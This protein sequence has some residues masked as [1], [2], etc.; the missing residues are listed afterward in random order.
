M[1]HIIPLGKIIETPQG[2]DAIHIAIAPMKAAV[3]LIPGQDVGV[4]GENLAGPCENNIGIVDPF[5]KHQV[6]PD[7][8]FFMLLYPNKITSLRH[9]WEHPAFVEAEKDPEKDATLSKAYMEVCAK[10][11][12]M[13]YE[14][15]METAANYQ[16]TGWAR[17]EGGRFEG[18]WFDETEFWNHYEVLTGTKVE[19]NDRGQIFSCSC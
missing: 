19:E 12:G 4:V 11:A 10:E 17:V 6:L 18:V 13:S 8:E 15:L 1:S 7:Q 2:R 3:R 9:E 16:K 5:L 14:E